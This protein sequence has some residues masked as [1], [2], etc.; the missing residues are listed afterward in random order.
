MR[1]TVGGAQR[2]E[3]KVDD[4]N[5]GQKLWWVK[6]VVRAEWI[7]NQLAATPARLWRAA[8]AWELQCSGKRRKKRAS[9]PPW[10]APLIAGRSGLRRSDWWH[11]RRTPGG[12]IS[13]NRFPL[14]VAAMRAWG[15]S[16]SDGPTQLTPSNWFLHYSKTVQN[17]KSNSN[18]VLCSK[19][20]E[21]LHAARFGD[22]E[23]LSPLAQLEIPTPYH[24]IILWTDSYLNLPR[25]LKGSNLVGETW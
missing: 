10:G 4:V 8:A 2:Q 14:G 3:A 20:A 11:R 19:N 9:S 12:A 25:I 1:T 22:D 23:Q 16:C 6:A 13:L 18:T 21:T 5:L 17:L 24:G 15:R 7:G